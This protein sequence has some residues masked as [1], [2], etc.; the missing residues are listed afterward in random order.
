MLPR[1]ASKIRRTALLPIVLL[2]PG[3]LSVRV[4][5]QSL[6]SAMNPLVTARS[7]TSGALDLTYLRP[8]EGRKVSNYVYDGFGPYPIAGAAF[9][10]GIN[11]L[12]DSP[13]EWNQGIEGF[14]KRFGSNLGIAVVGT[15]TRY[16]LAEALR[17]DT[18]YYRCQCTGAF[19]RLRHAAIS[20]FIARLGD[21]GHRVFSFPALIAPYAGSLV[22]VY[23]WYPD[24]FGAKDAFRMGSYGLLAYMG[25][26]ISLEFFYSGRHSLLA[27]MHLNNAHGSKIQGPNQ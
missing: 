20:T 23:G 2:I 21:D 3:S 10:A 18:L 4:R 15:S 22:A 19:R 9:T 11:Q 25:E 16:G 24:H 5:S 12:S 7:P 6:S 14:S 17:E 13:P 8:T 27:R 1:V 26:N